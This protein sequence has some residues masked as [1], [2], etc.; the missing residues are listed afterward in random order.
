MYSCFVGFMSAEDLFAQ[1]F[2]GSQAFGG[3]HPFGGGMSFGGFGGD[4]ASGFGSMFGGPQQGHPGRQQRQAKPE[5]VKRALPCT[6]EEL[7]N[8][9]SKKLKITRNVQDAS[10]EVRQESN[11]L[12]VEGKPGWK[13][14]TKLTFP[15]VSSSSIWRHESQ[16]LT[17]MSLRLTGW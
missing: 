14:G 13:A 6:L 12:V 17:V 7:Y 11:V 8:G 5:V 2:G 4:D 16:L 9:F 1:F 3:S 10:G 15:A